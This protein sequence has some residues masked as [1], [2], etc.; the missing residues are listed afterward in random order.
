MDGEDQQLVERL[1]SGDESAFREIVSRYNASM[2]RVARA[3]V[4]SD[5]I[6]E[7]VVQET[8]MHLYNGIGRFEGRSSFKTWLFTILRNRAR[9]RGT[10]EAR[11]RPFSSVASSSEDRNAPGFDVDR[12]EPRDN[13]ITPPNY[14]ELSSPSDDVLRV[15]LFDEVQTALEKLPENQKMVVTLRDL[16]GWSSPEVQDYLKV[17]EANQRVLLHRGRAR[18]RKELAGYMAAED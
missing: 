17:S 18:M 7:E 1:K 14:A 5:D 4:K 15:E 11:T 3:F 8:W 2:L 9:T 13:W 6:A 16:L 12:T 10:R